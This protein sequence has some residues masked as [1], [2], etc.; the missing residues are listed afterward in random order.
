MILSLLGNVFGL[1]KQQGR[2]FLVNPGYMFLLR[3]N[4]I[5]LFPSFFVFDCF[6]IIGKY[7]CLLFKKKGLYFSLNIVRPLRSLY[8]FSFDETNLRSSLYFIS[9]SAGSSVIHVFKSIILGHT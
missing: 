9:L 6:S 5:L 1:M 7:F 3:L 4:T 2:L 8:Q